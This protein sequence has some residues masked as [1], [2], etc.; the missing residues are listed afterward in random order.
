MFE[1]AVANVFRDAWLLIGGIFA[2]LIFLLFLEAWFR[3][4]EIRRR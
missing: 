4:K 3:I 1:D 2:V